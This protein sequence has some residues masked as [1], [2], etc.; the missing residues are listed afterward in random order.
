[1]VNELAPST[2]RETSS[3]TKKAPYPRSTTPLVTSLKI[4]G[5]PAAMMS[6]QQGSNED[7]LDEY[8]MSS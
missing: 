6:Q 2:S 7:K 3:D 1:M 4:D 5:I 8:A